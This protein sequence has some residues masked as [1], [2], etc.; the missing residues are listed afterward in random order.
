MKTKVLIFTA[1]ILSV[2]LFSVSCA[3]DEPADTS[4]DVSRSVSQEES[5]N[6]SVSEPEES[7]PEE[8]KPEESKP[9]ESKPE[10]SKPEESEPEVSVPE[11]SKPEEEP[12]KPMISEDFPE[13]P[14]VI[15]VPKGYE[16]IISLINN[17]EYRKAFDLLQEKENDI[18]AIQ[19]LE[20]FKEFYV[21][22]NFDYNDK[23]RNDDGFTYVQYSLDKNGTPV[24]MYRS[25][26][27]NG[28]YSESVTSYIFNKNGLFEGGTRD[29]LDYHYN[30]NGTLVKITAKRNGYSDTTVFTWY[31]NGLLATEE[32]TIHTSNDKIRGIRYAYDSNGRMIHRE[33]YSS[34]QGVYRIEKWKHDSEGRIIEE[35]VNSEVTTYT[36]E[37]NGKLIK[38]E[39]RFYDGSVAIETLTYDEKG[40]LLVDE[41]KKGETQI[42]RYVYEYD[43]NGY[44]TSFD[45]K[46][47]EHLENDYCRYEYTYDENG[48]VIK[49]TEKG[50]ND[51]SGKVDGVVE[52]TYDE[53]GDLIKKT[54][55]CNVSG[56]HSVRDYE[57]YNVWYHKYLKHCDHDLLLYIE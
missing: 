35:T 18:Y 5:V 49:M 30:T 7:E 54:H 16:E 15:T 26:Y 36:Y 44:R 53:N 10:E 29:D 24:S 38:A 8:S 1:L 34:D 20:N 42:F 31:G 13:T 22:Q 55:F 27:S 12:A 41:K 47:I 11:E 28:G 2:I 9:E 57:G 56:S 33:Y 25:S 19:L 51:H 37:E 48:R 45:Y 23:V 40:N 21:K 50:Y 3:A 43:E 6:E 52:Y 46:S 39:T 4:E 14:E 17:G 32:T